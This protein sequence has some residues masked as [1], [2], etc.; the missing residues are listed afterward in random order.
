MS[1]FFLKSLNSI[2]FCPQRVKLPLSGHLQVTENQECAGGNYW[3][4]YHLLLSELASD[5]LYQQ[6]PSTLSSLVI[7]VAIYLFEV[8][9]LWLTN[10]VMVFLPF[11][12]LL[13]LNS[14][15]AY[16]IRKSLEKYDGDV[17]TKFEM[18]QTLEFLS[19]T[20]E[21]TSEFFVFLK[22]A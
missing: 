3:Q 18:N 5:P 2:G 13:L 12:A 9:A 4:S 15:I 1:F 7:C 21:I 19:T 11:L 14:I 10:I 8:Y 16:T 6:V 22:S 17:N 20:R